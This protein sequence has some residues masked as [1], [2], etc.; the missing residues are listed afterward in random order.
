MSEELPM[1]LR[2]VRALHDGLLLDCL[3]DCLEHLLAACARMKAVEETKHVATQRVGRTR[4]K[5][6]VKT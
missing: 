5:Y 6:G 1:G 4:G 3:Y 2:Q